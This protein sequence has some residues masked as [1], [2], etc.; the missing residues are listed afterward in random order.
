MSIP[1]HS[2]VSVDM[3]SK[4][5]TT[6]FL[7]LRSRGGMNATIEILCAES[8]ERPLSQD[9]G[10]GPPPRRFK[11]DRSQYNGNELYGPVD[12]YKCGTGDNTYEPF[13]F[14]TFRYVRLTVR[15]QDE[16]LN[17]MGFDYRATHYPLDV[18][19]VVKSA[20]D[21]HDM[22]R[23]SLNTLRN[24]MHET[25]EDCPY[26]EQ[27]QFAMD[28]RIQILFTYQ[29]SRDDR[30]ARKT[31]H[32]FHASRRDDG[33]IETHFPVPF[34]SINIPQFSLYWILM[35]HDH[36]MYFGDK[37]LLRTYFGTMDGILEHFN[38]RINNQGLVGKFDDETWPFVDWVKEWFAPGGLQFMGIPPAYR[39]YGAATYNSLIY[40]MVLQHA[41]ELCE[42]INRQDVAKEYRHRAQALN[43][44][45]NEHCLV[46]GI[47]VDGPGAVEAC[48]HN[49]IFAVLSGAVQGPSAAELL[50]T[51]VNNNNLPK[52]TF[53]MSFYVFRA[54]A[55]VGLYEELFPTIIEPWKKMINQNLTTWAEDDT[56]FRSDCH[57]WSSAPIY[58]IVAEL[59]GLKPAKPGYEILSIEPKF[60]QTGEGCFVVA[61][62][63]INISVDS[64]PKRVTVE[65]NFDA[66]ITTNR[67]GL[68]SAKKGEPLALV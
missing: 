15:T 65:A 9:N 1:A 24:C 48:Q 40:A 27:N 56:M 2:E 33:L 42:W 57:G 37:Q 52:C 67:V 22:W 61:G 23:I 11:D 31:I 4:V 21:L 41:A 5:L 36:M 19:T 68:V 43:D 59:F 53:A 46:D 10:Q 25:Y 17:I 28:S 51:A 14:R 34:R 66:T 58:E 63:K 55:K 47:Y 54:A 8:Y 64:T 62:G 12:T 26:Y 49:Q 50:R 7:S 35:L 39:Q 60:Q 13:W 20:P 18:Q 38:Q 45:V 32:E 44:A 29:I 16:P 30:L 3:E 6:G